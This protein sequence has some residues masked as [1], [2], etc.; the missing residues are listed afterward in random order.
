MDKSNLYY[1]FL[2]PKLA[3]APA[4]PNPIEW[5]QFFSQEPASSPPD[6]SPSCT[7]SLSS[8]RYTLFPT[9]KLKGMVVITWTIASHCSL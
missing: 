5:L 7:P 6:G 2:S 8:G 9:W 1:H 4:P 3:V